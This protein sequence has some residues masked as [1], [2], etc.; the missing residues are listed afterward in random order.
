MLLPDWSTVA[1]VISDAAIELG[2]T[3]VDIADPFASP[4][5]NI[6]QLLRLLKSGCKDIVTR[7]PWKHLIKEFTFN[8]AD[9]VQAY[10]L[11]SDYRSLIDD[12]AWDRS[13]RFPLGGP[14]SSEDWQFLQAVP[15]ASAI[16]YR[17]RIWQGQLFLSQTP[18]GV[19]DLVAFEYNSSSFVEPAGQ[20]LPTSDMPAAATDIVCFSARL[21]VARLK[22]D[23]RRNKKQDSQSEEE[24][25][26]DAL[27]DAENED[28]QGRTIYLGGRRGRTPR[29]IDRW[30]LPDVIR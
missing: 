15:V 8:L 14:L 11:P 16:S 18:S 13:T 2:L 24:D 7:R 17:Y 27:Y 30:N 9:G 20:T 4:D 6:L 1:S 3:P 12:S 25:Y 26:R 28:A 10:P 19:T 21:V 23:F 5:S 29:R 22:R